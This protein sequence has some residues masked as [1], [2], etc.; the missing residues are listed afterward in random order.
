MKKLRV[1]NQNGSVLLALVL[2]LPSLI[3][4]TS[5]YLQLTVSS[6]RVAQKDQLHTHAQLATDAGIDRSLYEINRD[7]TWAGTGTEIELHNDGSTKTT[8]QV[9]AMSNGPDNKIVTSTG[10]SYRPASST[11]PESFVT[12]KVDLRAVKAGNFSIVTGVGGLF[13]TNRAK[14]VG[15]DVFVNGEIDLRNSAQI[16]LTTN[17]VKVD[18]AH[19]NCPNPPD[20]T[21]PRT[22]NPGENG[23]PISF[24][25]RAHIYG[26]VKANN[27]ISGTDMSNPGLVASSGVA[28]QPLPPH[29]RD[30]QKAAVTTTITGAAASCSDNE[31][32]TWAANTK[33]TGDV[34]VTN[35][36]DVT[37]LGN[38]WITGTLETRNS[39]QVIVSDALGATQPVIM[40]D[41]VSAEFNNRTCLK[42]MPVVPVSKLLPTKA[43]P[44]V[45]RIVPALRG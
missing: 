20:A 37:V 41:G 31:T 44:L 35:R 21:Y 12:V 36:C 45:H 29:D 17:S 19:Q 24:R 3:L 9:T 10:R 28:A 22:C 1:L 8:Y 16:G 11:T 7:A 34:T 5:L 42:A 39:T 27:Q 32:R 13:M 33:I 38:V 43:M 25:N 2:I 23:E 14:I 15:G 26:T 30:A 40:I 18:V 4:I 6:L